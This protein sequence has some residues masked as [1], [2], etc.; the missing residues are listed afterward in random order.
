MAYGEGTMLHGH[1]I[2]SHAGELHKHGVAIRDGD[3]IDD[4]SALYAIQ[5]VRQIDLMCPGIHEALLRQGLHE[6]FEGLVEPPVAGRPH[7]AR[8]RKLQG[9]AQDTGV[10]TVWSLYGPTA[11]R[12]CRNCAAITLLTSVYNSA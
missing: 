3:R 7:Y 1:R 8:H 5:R 11:I 10:S 12:W 2:V 4:R 6:A 9:G